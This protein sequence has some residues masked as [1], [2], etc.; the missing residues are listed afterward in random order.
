MINLAIAVN[1]IA[2]CRIVLNGIGK[3]ADYVLA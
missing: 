1:G 2:E 3:P